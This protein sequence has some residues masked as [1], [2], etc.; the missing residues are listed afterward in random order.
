MLSLGLTK[1]WDQQG[2]YGNYIYMN[3][4]EGM[5]IRACTHTD[6]YAFMYLF[7]K[8]IFYPSM[9][10]DGGDEHQSDFLFHCLQNKWPEGY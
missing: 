3:F 4:T 7:G 6:R 5:Y 9:I 2:T 8:C 1:Q 10:A